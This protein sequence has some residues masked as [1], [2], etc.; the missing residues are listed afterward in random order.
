[1]L[2][3][4]LCFGG[5]SISLSLKAQRDDVLVCLGRSQVTF[6]I[7]AKLL[8]ALAFT[9]KCPSL[10]N[11]LHFHP[12]HDRWKL[13]EIL[14]HFS[15]WPQHPPWENLAA[16]MLVNLGSR[17]HGFTVLY[18]LVAQSCP[19]L[20]DPVNRSTPASLSITNSQSSH[21]PM[22][23]KSV[24]PSNHLIL[25][26][27]L[28]LLPSIFPSIRVF[29]NESALCIMWPKYSVSVSTSVLPMNTQD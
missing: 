26:H 12:S 27:P 24:M 20:C 4:G 29:S 28:L 1:M 16:C 25:C 23:I 10:D 6:L 21:K 19:T 14:Y 11:R 9:Q 13:A 3:I 2:T 22:S 17:I 7:L 8:I 5:L 15:L 18:S